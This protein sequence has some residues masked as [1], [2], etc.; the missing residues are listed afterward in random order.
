MDHRMQCRAGKGERRRIA[1]RRRAPRASNGA[2]GRIICLA[3]Q[4]AQASAILAGMYLRISRTSC[5]R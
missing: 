5:A 4:R 1:S 2:T 3:V